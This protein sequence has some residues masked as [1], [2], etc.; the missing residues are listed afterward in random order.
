M[1]DHRPDQHTGEAG[2]S[3]I[4]FVLVLPVLIILFMGIFEIGRLLTQLGPTSSANYGAGLA[5]SRSEPGVAQSQGEGAAGRLFEAHKTDTGSRFTRDGTSVEYDA[6]TR[7]Y[8]VHTDAQVAPIF[9]AL[10]DGR[11]GVDLVLPSLLHQ[12]SAG[13]PVAEGGEFYSGSCQYGPTGIVDCAASPPACCVQ[14]QPTFTPVPLPTRTS[15]PVCFAGDTL[16]ARYDGVQMPIELIQPGD[17]VYCLNEESFEAQ[18]GLVT[19]VLTAV[20]D[21][22][23]LINGTLRVTPAHRFFINAAWKTAQD[24][25]PGDIFYSLNNEI[26]LVLSVE[27]RHE[28]LV[29][30]NLTVEPCHTYFAGGVL[31][32]NAKATPVYDARL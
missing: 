30:H 2:A 11:L 25:L 19:S 1:C 27:A 9:G 13:T 15:A 26:V 5:A 12:G 21:E 22:Y 18:H 20:T 29:V 17:V 28:P 31:V 23:I 10:S 32:H 4:E 14:A 3:L 16:I 7:S 8:R 6:A 24:L